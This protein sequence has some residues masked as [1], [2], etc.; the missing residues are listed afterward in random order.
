MKLVTLL[1]RLW[2]WI[3]GRFFPA[4]FKPS[5][6]GAPSG[7]QPGE[8]IQMS[9]RSYTVQANGEWRRNI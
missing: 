7:Y 4:D 2:A 3:K 6:L 8:V 1:V 5:P 9:D